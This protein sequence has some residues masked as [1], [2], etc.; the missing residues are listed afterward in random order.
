MPVYLSVSAEWAQPAGGYVF[1]MTRRRSQRLNAIVSRTVLALLLSSP[2]AAQGQAVA[3]ADQRAA[4]PVVP[5]ELGFEHRR[6]ERLQE[7]QNAVAIPAPRP[8][9]E[10]EGEQAGLFTLAAVRIEGA[11]PLDSDAIAA[12][13]SERLGQPISQPGLNA[14]AA[15]ITKLHRD[16]GFHLTR[17][18]IPPQTIK[19]GTVVIRIIPGAVAELAVRGDESDRFGTRR[20]LAPIAEESPARLATLERQLLLVNDLPGVRVKDTMLEEIGTGSGRFRLTVILDSWST[21]V[22][23]GIDNGASNAVG[24][25]QAYFGAAL[26]SIVIPGDTLAVNLSSVPGATRELRYGRISYDAPIVGDWLR[27]GIAASRSIVWPGD[28]RRLDS[29]RS[30]AENLELR[31]T[32]VA[33]QTQRQ[34]LS[35]TASLGLSNVVEESAFGVNYRDRLRIASL[36]ADYRVR[37]D[38]QGTTYASVNLR[39]GLSVDGASRRFDPFLSRFDGSGDFYVIQGAL[40]RYQGLGENWSMK[41]SAAGQASSSALLISQ[42][43]YLGGAAFGRAFQSGWLAGDN[44]IAGSAELRY[45]FKPMTTLIKNVQLFGFVEGGTVR[46]YGAP[47]DFVQS[48]SAAGAGI[49]VQLNDSVEAGVTVAAPLTYGSPSRGG[50]GA[51]VLFSLTTTLRSCPERGEWRCG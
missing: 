16:A 34:S 24:P 20:M 49:R 37:D 28:L 18:I 41:L 35:L 12:S 22:S 36:S 50:R 3:Q 47:K 2:L 11:S 44:G 30:D 10:A 38:W 23:A 43:F 15:A 17:A 4:V 5:A 8:V 14:L 9:A 29:V 7:S 39:K 46:S 25:W 13:Y 51:T 33:L 31:A 26:N 42:Q 27:V 32:I 19:R 1:D 45:D 48:L 40:T 6:A 21:F